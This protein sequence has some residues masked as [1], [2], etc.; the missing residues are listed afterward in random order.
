[1]CAKKQNVLYIL[2][3]YALY[4]WATYLC[5]CL[6]FVPTT[7]VATV[8]PHLQSGPPPFYFQ[9]YRCMLPP[10]IK[11]LMVQW[12]C[13]MH[14]KHSWN[15]R[16]CVLFPRGSVAMWTKRVNLS[17][18]TAPMVSLLAIIQHHA[19]KPSDVTNWIHSFRV[20]QAIGS[21]LKKN[22]PF[23][24]ATCIFWYTLVHWI[25]E[26]PLNSI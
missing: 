18:P 3:F 23:P 25:H 19:I 5:L 9:S 26:R 6:A 12:W 11:V 1:M 20:V 4:E 13:K 17:I 16:V 14:V 8:P 7:I 24:L 15:T 2:L 22:H 21:K 10:Q